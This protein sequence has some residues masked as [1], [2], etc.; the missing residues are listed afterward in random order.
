[1][2]GSYKPVEFGVCN[3]NVIKINESSIFLHT[4]M[5]FVI[6]M[7]AECYFSST[8][9]RFVSIHCAAEL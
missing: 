9:L 1:M 2:C 6:F 4:N 5:H 7:A 8:L 3:E